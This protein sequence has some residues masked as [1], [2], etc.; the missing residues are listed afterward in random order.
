[1]PQLT[2]NGVGFLIHL[3]AQ[4]RIF[5]FT[6][7]TML[8]TGIGCCYDFQCDIIMVKRKQPTGRHM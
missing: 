7:I 4:D 2:M 6:L 8:V 5:I 1:M 3:T